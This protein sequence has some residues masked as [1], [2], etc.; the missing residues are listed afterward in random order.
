MNEVLFVKQ[1][2]DHHHMHHYYTKLDVQEYPKKKKN[3]HE[4]RL[5]VLYEYMVAKI[6]RLPNNQK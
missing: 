2:I 5:T 4:V 6:V 1:L 3:I